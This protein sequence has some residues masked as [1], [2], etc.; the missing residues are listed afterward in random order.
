MNVIVCECWTVNVNEI[1]ERVFVNDF[2]SLLAGNHCARNRNGYSLNLV[3]AAGDDRNRLVR[4]LISCLELLDELECPHSHDDAAE[5]NIL[6]VEE[7]EGSA[8]RDIELGL[9]RVAQTVSLAHAEH[10]NLL[11]LNLE[12]LVLE[13]PAVDGRAKL[14][15][16][17]RHDSAHLNVHALDDA[18][19]ISANVG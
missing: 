5:D 4:L 6:V 2:A 19:Y 11:V 12:R 18:V 14:G 7:G 16:L 15:C 8:H 17:G 3:G 10:A 13:G 9:V 1:R